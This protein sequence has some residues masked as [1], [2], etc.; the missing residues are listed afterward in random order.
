MIGPEKLEEIEGMAREAL[1]LNLTTIEVA[2]ASIALDLV[3]EIR[4]LAAL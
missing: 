3:A 1:A 4:R 2:W